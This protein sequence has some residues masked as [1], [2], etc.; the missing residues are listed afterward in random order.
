ML[1]IINY[2]GDII[3][4]CNSW[5]NYPTYVHLFLR[6]TH[7]SY[8]KSHLNKPPSLSRGMISSTTLS[9]CVGL[10]PPFMGYCVASGIDNEGRAH[11]LLLVLD[12]T[13]HPMNG[14]SSPAQILRITTPLP[15]PSPLCHLLV[16][17]GELQTQRGWGP[18]KSVRGWV[19]FDTVGDGVDVNKGTLRIAN[20]KGLLENR[21]F[22]VVNLQRD[23]KNPKKL[24]WHKNIWPLTGSPSPKPF[25]DRSLYL[26]YVY[27]HCTSA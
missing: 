5:D 8:R 25:V 14:G 1:R 21:W 3:L 9:I 27:Y 15:D 17:H 24:T 6:V 7:F 19:A 23:I 18:A 4:T 10:E 2:E 16:S 26:F 12:T 22:R 11:T 20:P 13:R